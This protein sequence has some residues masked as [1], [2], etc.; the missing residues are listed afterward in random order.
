MTAIVC[1]VPNCDLPV[2]SQGWCGAHAER[3]RRTGKLSEHI[4]IKRRAEM[5]AVCTIEGCGGTVGGGGLC[6]SHYVAAYRSGFRANGQQA[7]ACEVDGC[8]EPLR[9]KGYC[10]SHYAKWRRWGTPIPPD[11]PKPALRVRDKRNGYVMVKDPTNPM[12]MQNGY[13]MEHRVVM[14]EMLGRPLVK[15]ENVHHINGTRDDNRP[16][17]L[18]LWNT[19]QPAG[20]RISD[21]VSWAL[22]ILGLY[23]PEHLRS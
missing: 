23:A 2:K 16:E 11:R 8:D 4:P 10:Q 7:A 18:E 5:P 13:V 15:H 12:A 21:K 19:Y 3:V 22:E 1:S 6:H 9:S 14:A 17:N 20:Q